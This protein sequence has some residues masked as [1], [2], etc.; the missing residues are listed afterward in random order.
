MSIVSEV[1]GVP[2]N[3]VMP[4]EIGH[5]NV[6][7]EGATVSEM[8][9]KLKVE[10]SVKN[11]ELSAEERAYNPLKDASAIIPWQSVHSR[12]LANSISKIDVAKA[13]IL[14]LTYVS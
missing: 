10:P 13:M 11:V 7:V 14:I 2:L 8:T 5:T 3:V 4:T 6:Q 1:M 12:H 9:K